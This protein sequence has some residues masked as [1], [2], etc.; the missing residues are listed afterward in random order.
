VET[1]LQK[2]KVS[3]EYTTAIASYRNDI[4]FSKKIN[5]ILILDGT[6]RGT[7]PNNYGENDFIVSYVGQY[8]A[9]FRHFKTNRR[10]QHD[11]TFY[12]Y[13]K[14]DALYMR[15]TVEGVDD[16]NFETKM[17]AIPIKKPSKR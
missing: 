13:K 11:Y 17:E 2:E 3:V 14:E 7:I 12:L 6:T 16:M 10:H 8:Y 5:H 4:N 9:S 1:P 15:V